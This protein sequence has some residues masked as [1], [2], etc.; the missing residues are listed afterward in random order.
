M[1]SEELS[2]RTQNIRFAEAI[3]KQIPGVSIPAY[4]EIPSNVFEVLSPYDT[5]R[6]QDATSTDGEFTKPSFDAIRHYYEQF[7]AAGINDVISHSVSPLLDESPVIVR[8]APVVDATHSH[9]SF[10]G[11]YPSFVPKPFPQSLETVAMAAS[12]VIAGKHTRY[13]NYYHHRHNIAAR[14]MGVLVM[15]LVT[16]PAI[17]GTAYS[18]EHNV[19]SEHVFDPSLGDDQYGACHF[20]KDKFGNTGSAE[21]DDFCTEINFSER[22]TS[23]MRKLESGF[24]HSVDVEYLVD[25][26][27]VIHVVQIRD[28]SLDHKINWR[29][30]YSQSSSDIEATPH[31]DRRAIINSVGIVLGRIAEYRED[32]RPTLMPNSIQV[33]SNSMTTSYLEQLDS[34]SISS[35]GEL[36]VVHGEDRIRDHL[37]YATLEDP[38]IRSLFHTVNSDGIINET[39]EI[40]V[41]S[42]GDG[43]IKLR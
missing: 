33:I 17:H 40:N 19:R 27:G 24:R 22:L 26:N 15:E 9:L 3:I 20:V 8:C 23:L 21:S 31:A 4:T 12:S 43:F 2:S 34:Q 36:I 30:Y 29:K 6:T 13:A 35:A 14:R 28:M 7:N 38:S 18:F 10:A 39:D 11:T 1:S 5:D 41:Y 16:A 25:K 42:N 37:Q 32:S